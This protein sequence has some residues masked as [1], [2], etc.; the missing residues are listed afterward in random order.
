[1]G[2]YADRV[3]PRLV[4]RVMNRR[5]LAEI[6][7]RV[8]AELDGE[9]LEVGFGSGLNLPHYPPSVT[10]VR[11]VDPATL[12]RRLAAGRVAASA[13][14]VEYVGLDGQDL[15]LDSASVDH[16]LTTW[17]LCT[18]PDVG[19]ALR[20]VARVLRRGGRL[21]FVEH[22]RSP[23]PGVARWQDRL[24]PVQRRLAGGCHLNRRID[25]LVAQS[26]LRLTRMTTYYIRG[27]RALGYT[28]EG[29]AASSD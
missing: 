18:I 26:G 14:P 29:V 10:R 22:G 9:V 17:T 13:V 11:A 28:F 16:V 20:E 8:A 21:H 25:E 4:D 15:A 24:T 12:G 27:P 5:D 2:W 7:A 3:L 19:R 6:R 1:M 23:D